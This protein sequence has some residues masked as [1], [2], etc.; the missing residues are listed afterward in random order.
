MRLLQRAGAVPILSEAQPMAA[1]QFAVLAGLVPKHL[2]KGHMTG[3]MLGLKHGQ[4][5]ADIDTAVGHAVLAAHDLVAGLVHLLKG[6]LVVL[7]VVAVPG[8]VN[9][10][11]RRARRANGQ[12]RAGAGF[13]DCRTVA[14]GI[15]GIVHTHDAVAAA[16]HAH[17]SGGA[18]FQPLKRRQLSLG[19][20]KFFV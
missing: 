18:E 15:A 11:P 8:S 2:G 17:A 6:Y 13:G 19:V 3:L 12:K 9:T 4:S 1:S 7:A 14:R 16:K 5:D 10:R 20:P